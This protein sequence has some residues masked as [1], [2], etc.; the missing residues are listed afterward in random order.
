MF[1]VMGMFYMCSNGA[2]VYAAESGRA[3]DESKEHS[4]H[5]VFIF[6]GDRV[7][8]IA[9]RSA[10]SLIVFDYSTFYCFVS[11]IKGI[12]IVS[13]RFYSALHT[14][15]LSA[16]LSSFFLRGSLLPLSA[17][18]SNSEHFFLSMATESRKENDLECSEFSRCYRFTRVNF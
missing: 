9:R 17:P 18:Q 5:S 10:H 16:S 3:D 2:T 6:V 11:F 8:S 1:I 12:I 7:F 13:T 14:F 4:T 15:L